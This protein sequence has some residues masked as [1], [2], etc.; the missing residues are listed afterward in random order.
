M[1]ENVE[2]TCTQ[3]VHKAKS[4]YYDAKKK[5]NLLFFGY[6]HSTMKPDNIAKNMRLRRRLGKIILLLY[7]KIEV[8]KNLPTMMPENIEKT[9]YLSRDQVKITVL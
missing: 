3:D 8:I 9:M 1:P 6:N 4:Q 7:P 5:N 2:K